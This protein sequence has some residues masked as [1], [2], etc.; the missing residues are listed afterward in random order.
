MK[1]FLLIVVIVI[2]MNTKKQISKDHYLMHF[3]LITSQNEKIIDAISELP[4]LESFENQPI[5]RQN[6]QLG[7]LKNGKDFV[8]FEQFTIDP[9]EE[10]ILKQLGVM[11]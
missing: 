5:I 11:K 10:K 4:I 8:K 3:G 2:L 1:E 9:Y 6:Y 7:Y